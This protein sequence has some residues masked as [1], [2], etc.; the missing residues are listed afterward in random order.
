MP[1]R[2]RRS[3]TGLSR[4]DIFL[5]G[6]AAAAAGMAAGTPLSAAPARVPGTDPYTKIGVRPFINTTATL[7]IN[8]GS[9]MLPEVIASIEQ[10]SQYHVNLDE[11]MDTDGDHLSRLLQVERGIVTARGA[12]E[13]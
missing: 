6:S 2:T 12:L 8:G 7:T 5:R 1:I 13:A 10:A 9:Q 3:T 11:L 4:R